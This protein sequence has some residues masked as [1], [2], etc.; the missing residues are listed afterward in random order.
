MVVKNDL[1]PT[2]EMILSVSREFG[3]PLTAEDFGG[4]LKMLFHSE[5]GMM[6]GMVLCVVWCDVWHGIVCGMV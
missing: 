4:E 3:I 6:C 1:F 2:P 5:Y